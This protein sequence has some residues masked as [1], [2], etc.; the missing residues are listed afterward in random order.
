[1]RD[2]RARAIIVMH[3][4]EAKIVLGEMQETWRILVGLLMWTLILRDQ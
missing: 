3:V 4:Q 1:M 2:W